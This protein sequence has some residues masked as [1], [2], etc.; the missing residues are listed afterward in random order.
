M[1][2]VRAGLD[3]V[4]HR[5]VALRVQGVPAHMGDLQAPD[6]PARSALTSPPIQSRPGLVSYSRP[7]VAMS[8]MPTQMP[9]NGRPRRAPPRSAPRPC[10]ARRRARAGNPRRRRRPAA[11]SR[12]AR[13]TRVGIGGDRDGLGEA[14][15]ARRALEGLGGRVQVAR[16]VIDDRDAHR[17]R[18]ASG[19]RPITGV[20]AR[21]RPATDEPGGGRARRR[22]GRPASRAGE[23]LQ[24]RLVAAARRHDVDDRAAAPRE[25]PAPQAVGLEAD[26]DREQD[27]GEPRPPRGAGRAPPGGR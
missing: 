12:S 5:V 21:R 26:Q 17:P 27:L 20:G 13:R 11:R 24:L 1:Q 14:R 15:L 19:K 16:A 8:C 23:G 10:R 2:A 4:E 18:S 25:G 7:R 3:A 6:R 9:R 22:P